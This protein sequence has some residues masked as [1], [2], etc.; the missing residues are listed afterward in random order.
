[1]VPKKWRKNW[2]DWSLTR[3]SVSR[4]GDAMTTN[5][6]RETELANA[7]RRVG[8]S[9]QPLKALLAIWEL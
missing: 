5:G 9:G 6:G 7:H 4:I 8:W 3:I 2:K 1:M